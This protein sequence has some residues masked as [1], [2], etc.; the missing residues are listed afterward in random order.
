MAPLTGLNYTYGEIDETIHLSFANS[1][2][3]ADWYDIGSY[4]R[5][6]L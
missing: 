3:N 1:K 2:S 4:T 5:C 6:G